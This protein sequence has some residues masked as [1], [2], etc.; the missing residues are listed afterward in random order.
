MPHPNL[1]TNGF[2]HDSR[3]KVPLRSI[4]HTYRDCGADARATGDGHRWRSIDRRTRLDVHN[5]CQVATAERPTAQA[6]DRSRELLEQRGLAPAPE[7]HQNLLQGVKHI[8]QRGRRGGRSRR[9][10]SLWSGALGNLSVQSVGV[11]HKGGG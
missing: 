10:I 7:Q 1:P 11:E 8:F 9:V 3:G 5:L 2:L 6:L 4:Y